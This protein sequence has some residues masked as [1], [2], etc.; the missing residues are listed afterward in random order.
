LGIADA[1]T[2]TELTLFKLLVLP[3]RRARAPA[4]AEST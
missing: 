4:L 2:A 3:F 1:R